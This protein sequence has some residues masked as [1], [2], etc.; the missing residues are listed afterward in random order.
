[1][2]S[3]VLLSVWEAGDKLSAKHVVCLTAGV[4]SGEPQNYLVVRHGAAGESASVWL[5]GEGVP[6]SSWQWLWCALKLECVFVMRFHFA[7]GL[8]Q[9]YL[10]AAWCH[11]K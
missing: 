7:C 1:M 3:Y 9:Q 2:A 5:R 10:S 6:R 4:A 11:V 8:V